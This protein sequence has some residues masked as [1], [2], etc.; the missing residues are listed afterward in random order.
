M[1]EMK[2]NAAFWDTS[3]I[4]PLCVRQDISQEVRKLWRETSR[5]VV[6]W[7]TSIEVR[8]AV[9]RL[10]HGNFIDARG[11]Q[12]ALARLGVIRRKWAEIIPSEKVRAIA[13][14]LPDAYGLRAL[15]ACQL[16]AALVWCNEKPSGRIFICDDVKLSIAAQ[17]LGF[18]IKP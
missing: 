16:A 2:T 3:V 13:E 4:V 1:K 6:W 10:Y 18:S 5:V 8:S 14:N 7:G 15:D 9:S 11:L 12:F 17:K